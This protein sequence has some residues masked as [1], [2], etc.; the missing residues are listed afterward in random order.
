[1]VLPT[2]GNLQLVQRQLLGQSLLGKSLFREHI[3]SAMRAFLALPWVEQNELLNL[4][5]LFEELFHGKIAL[6][7]FGLAMH[8]LQQRDA[9]HA[10]KRMDADLAVG[11]VAKRFA[12]IG[13]G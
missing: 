7:S 2:V 10:V 13:K 3:G 6:S 12:M 8:I 9:Q 5:Q 11:P 4:L 1:M